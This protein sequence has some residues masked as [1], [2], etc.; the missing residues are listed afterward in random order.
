MVLLLVDTHLICQPGSG[1]RISALKGVEAQVLTLQQ[2]L[3]TL[4]ANVQ[5][6]AVVDSDGTLVR[7]SISAISASGSGGEYEV[8]FNRDVSECAYVAT[9]GQRALPGEISVTSLAVE[10]DGVFVVPQIARVRIRPAP[11]TYTCP[12]RRKF[13]SSPEV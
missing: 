7:G 11:S 8:I 2:E 9:I 6:F 13:F 4:Q 5:N 12:V 1:E 3:G 10:A